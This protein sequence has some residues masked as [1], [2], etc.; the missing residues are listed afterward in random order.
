LKYTITLSNV[1][2]SNDDQI[3]SENPSD[4]L[5]MARK[6]FFKNAPFLK[7]IMMSFESI[8]DPYL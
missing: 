4:I 7:L 8:S 1:R 2:I 3:L 5:E 6:M